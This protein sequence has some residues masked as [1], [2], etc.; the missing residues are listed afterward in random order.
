MVQFSMF[1]IIILTKILS[2]TIISGNAS[3]FNPETQNIEPIKNAYILVNTEYPITIREGYTDENGN[4]IGST[5]GTQYTDLEV[6][7]KSVGDAY[8][9]FNYYVVAIDNNQSSSG[10]SNYVSTWGE[11]FYKLTNIKNILNP[12]IPDQ[13]ELKQNYPNPFNPV[14]TIRYSLPRDSQVRIN[15]YNL[16]GQLVKTL[17]NNSKS[18]GFHTVS[19]N[20]KDNAREEIA[21]S[22][23]LY[24]IVTPE[25]T[26]TKKLVV[27][28]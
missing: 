18:A 15:V 23:Y 1:H 6:I 24:Q 20:I 9:Q 22:I 10:R 4:L 14:T 3:Y 2:Q 21:A 11:T 26:D 7:L 13:Y 17:I 5:T 19:W 25:F 28:K 12:V 8:D 16:K 27:M